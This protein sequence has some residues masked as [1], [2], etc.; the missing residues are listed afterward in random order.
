MNNSRR[1]FLKKG[2]L[3]T[4]AVALSG[5]M[6]G[7]AASVFE[8]KTIKI[9]SASHFGAFYAHV[10]NNKIVDIMNFGILKHNINTL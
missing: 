2:A 7:I 4:T 5:G 9:P 8:S 10:R 3:G 6:T 1:N